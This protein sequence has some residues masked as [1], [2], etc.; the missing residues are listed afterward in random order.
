M[1]ELT[2]LW[3]EESDLG[4]K[5]NAGP[6]VKNKVSWRTQNKTFNNTDLSQYLYLL[7]DV[8]LTTSEI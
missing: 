4:M 8:R 3:E 7:D 6:V 5:Q 2:V 1:K